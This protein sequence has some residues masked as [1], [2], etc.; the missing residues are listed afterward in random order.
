MGT[1]TQTNVEVSQL[2]VA[3]FGRAPDSGGLAYWAAL[4][5][6]GQSVAQLADAM[7]Q[8]APARSYFPE[9]LGAQEVIAS[10]YLNVL[11]RAADS[12]GLSFWT[13]KLGASGATPGSVIAELVAV[14]TSYAG[15]DPAGLLSAALFNNRSAA[16]NFYAEHSGSVE[17][18]TAVLARV[19]ADVASVEDA[20][21]LH[22]SA[23]AK[24]TYDARGFAALEMGPI[25]GDVTFVN[26]RAGAGLTFTDTLANSPIIPFQDPGLY[27]ITYKLADASSALDSVTLTLK[28]AGPIVVGTVWAPGVENL[29]VRGMDTDAVHHYNSVYLNGSGAQSLKSIGNT[30]FTFNSRNVDLRTYDGSEL[31]GTSFWFG[32]ASTGKTTASGGAANDGLGGG[33][34]DDHLFGHAGDDT[35]FGYGG[36]NVLT[37]GPGADLF[38]IAPPFDTDSLL[39]FNTI[40][41]FTPSTA[42]LPGDRIT[43]ADVTSYSAT[44]TTS[45]IQLPSGAS[46]AAYLDAAASGPEGMPISVTWFHFGA[47][48]YIAVD[49]S[50]GATFVNGV[51]HFIKLMGHVDLQGLA[52]TFELA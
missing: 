2:Y 38:M 36:R 30:D 9:G 35:F 14:V 18:A 49:K 42:S 23:G 17:Q 51:D 31:A 52:L 19:T 8:T 33:S 15:S 41:D 27:K 37:G 4:R 5:D 7:F 6:S 48:T 45:P 11:G 43:I 25:S 16:A 34:G 40:T 3:L 21:T 44:W 1:S 47:A 10:F 46:F 50:P 20:K 29:V 24:G 39:V 12:E 32:P 28:S 13:D 26:V 22:L